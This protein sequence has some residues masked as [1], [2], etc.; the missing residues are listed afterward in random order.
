MAVDDVGVYALCYWCVCADQGVY[1]AKE[2]VKIEWLTHQDNITWLY[3][4][5]RL[6]GTHQESWH[7]LEFFHTLQIVIQMDASHVAQVIVK[8]K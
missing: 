5:A 4:L 6:D 2:I 1:L 8:D 3:L 7:I